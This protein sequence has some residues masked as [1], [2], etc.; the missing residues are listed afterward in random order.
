MRPTASTAEHLAGFSGILQVDGYG[1]YA[2]LAQHGDIALAF[3]W[4]HVR[5][6]F[7][8]IQMQTAGADRPLS[9]S[10]RSMRSMPTFA[11]FPPTPSPAAPH[12]ASPRRFAPAARGPGCRRLRQSDHRRSNPLHALA[13]ERPYMLSSTGVRWIPVRGYRL[14]G[15]PV[16]RTIIDCGNSLCPPPDPYSPPNLTRQE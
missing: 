9:A 10:P 7:Y 4:S 2:Q 8:E 15:G 5:R 16:G 12:Q 13:L 11:V 6:Q 14:K 1:A 3:C